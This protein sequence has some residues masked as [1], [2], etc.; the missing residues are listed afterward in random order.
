MRTRRAGRPP[1]GHTCFS[2]DCVGQPQGR[3]AVEGGVVEG[4]VVEDADVAFVIGVGES[5]VGCCCSAGLFPVVE[6]SGISASRSI[7]TVS[8]CTADQITLPDG[9][10]E[11]G[12]PPS[13]R[14]R[15]GSPL[16]GDVGAGDSPDGIGS[17]HGN[18]PVIALIK[19]VL[20]EF[21]DSPGSVSGTSQHTNS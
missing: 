20:D 14:R 9:A 10:G 15:L 3:A 4:V 11:T 16:V 5:A 7:L 19:T 12:V 17:S 18:S 21:I 6:A 8:A 2:Q 13:S 1:G